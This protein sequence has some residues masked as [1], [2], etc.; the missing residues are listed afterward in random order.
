MTTTVKQKAWPWL[1]LFIDEQKPSS[2]HLAQG[3]KALLDVY[4]L[5][6]HL[7]LFLV[8]GCRSLRA[9]GVWEDAGIPCHLHVLEA[10]MAPEESKL[11]SQRAVLPLHAAVSPPN[12]MSLWES[13]RQCPAYTQES[14]QSTERG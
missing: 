6:V 3:R 14:I 1:L 9:E 13:V 10:P 7:I 8:W 12:S 2:N 4:V 11:L 5:E